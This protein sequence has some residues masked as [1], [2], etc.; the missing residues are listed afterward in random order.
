MKLNN[1]STDIEISTLLHA[2]LEKLKF[3]NWVK[4]CMLY[5]IKDFLPEY[6]FV[7]HIYS[8]TCDQGS[9]LHI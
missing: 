1:F 4:I 8:V 5:S 3:F 2:M 7:L 6:T 9:Y